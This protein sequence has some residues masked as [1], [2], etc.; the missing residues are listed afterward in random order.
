MAYVEHKEIPG[1]AHYF[2]LA[3]NLA[4]GC[5][6]CGY[7]L[8]GMTVVG[9]ILAVQLDYEDK[10]AYYNTM[11]SALTVLGL[12]IG[13]IASKPVVQMGR[14]RSILLANA[15][16]T[17]VTIPNF[18]VNNF[19]VLC[20]LRFILGL[21]SAV[22][23]NATSLYIGEAIPGVYMS[24]LGTTINTGIVTGIFITYVFGLFLPDPSKGP[25]G[26]QAALVDDLWR[27]SFSLQLGSV[28]ITT[29]LWL[30]VFK[31]EPIKFLLARAES[32]GHGSKAHYEAHKVLKLN[33]GLNDE[34]EVSETYSSVSEAI[35]A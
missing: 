35:S 10:K 27:V 9:D 8:A 28:L 13:A 3:L 33:Y 22:I 26:Y 16:I 15:L 20:V 21:C 4:M 2:G 34:H 29:L 6:N 24:T 19:A 1:V 23:V 11:I 12:T 18:W 31:N 5:F 32:Q 25:E 14:R 17:L 7:A 30:L